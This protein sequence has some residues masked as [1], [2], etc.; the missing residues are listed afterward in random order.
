MT[1][2]TSSGNGTIWGQVYP[3]FSVFSRLQIL[4]LMNMPTRMTTFLPLLPLSLEH[5]ILEVQIGLPG[6]P[7]GF[8]HHWN[9]LPALRQG[10][11]VDKSRA[12]LRLIIITGP[13][14]PIGWSD[15]VRI[16]AET[17]VRLDRVARDEATRWG[18]RWPGSRAQIED[19]ANDFTTLADAEGTRMDTG[20]DTRGKLL[21]EMGARNVHMRAMRS[22][23]HDE[24]DSM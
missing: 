23:I 16:A 22:S 10:L 5:L 17:G 19:G 20:R 2:R 18:R 7:H 11:K 21:E 15:P 1:A 14:E 3:H 6:A 12:S 24:M 9:L 13:G 8:I 4:T